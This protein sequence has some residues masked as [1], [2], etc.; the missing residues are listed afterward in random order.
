VLLRFAALLI[1]PFVLMGLAI[2]LVVGLPGCRGK[3]A[4]A[5]PSDKPV[6]AASVFPVADLARQVAADRWEVVTLLPPG[7]S[8]HSYSI[9]PAAAAALRSAKVLLAVGPGLDDWAI[10]A[11][12][13]TAGQRELVVLTEVLGLPPG[14]HTPA[15]RANAPA[16]DAGVAPMGAA[17]ASAG[18]I[19]PPARETVDEHAH[20]LAAQAADHA[21]HEHH[22]QDQDPHLWLDPVLTQRI[23]EQIAAVLSRHDP[24]GRA[25]YEQN[26]SRLEQDLARLH[27]DY[28]T[29]LAKVRI[30]TLVVFHPAYSYLAQ[31]YDLEQ[32]ALLGAAGVT[33]ARLEEVVRRIRR[34]SIGAVYRE[35][36]YE[37][38]WIDILGRRSGAKVL[39]L[40]PLGRAGVPGY[41][42]YLAM[43]RSNL[44]A[45]TEGLD[46]GP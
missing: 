21:G 28:R 24:A 26:A 12:R 23:V 5:G 34:D 35:P 4:A 8:P 22:P 36:Q 33:P 41:D 14:E 9:R 16:E 45:L 11:A 7:Q 19:R 43:M 17:G 42:S 37:S 29:T 38:K 44:A 31:R 18:G 39:V 10:Q 46:H 2:G 40:D 25:V 27:E 30:R 1:C 6:L 15:L 20:D 32:V 13:A 3:E